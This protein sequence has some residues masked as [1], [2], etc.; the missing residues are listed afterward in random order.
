MADTD[1]GID[2]EDQKRS[3]GEAQSEDPNAPVDAD[4]LADVMEQWAN[5]PDM[6]TA[7]GQLSAAI[8]G[9]CDIIAAAIRSRTSV[10]ASK[11]MLLALTDAVKAKQA[12]EEQGD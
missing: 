8:I 9:G 1:I 6:K 4:A 10:E 11:A 3:L 7:V 12:G 5:P 2:L